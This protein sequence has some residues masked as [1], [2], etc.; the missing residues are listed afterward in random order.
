MNKRQSYAS[1]ANKTHPSLFD[2]AFDFKLNTVQSDQIDRDISEAILS[3]ITSESYSSIYD[4]TGEWHWLQN[5][6]QHEFLSVLQEGKLDPLASYMAN[7]FRNQATYGY[8]SPSF[9]DI[10]QHN[11]VTVASDILCN[12]DTCIEFTDIESL[13]TLATPSIIGNPFGLQLISTFLLP[14]TPRHYYAYNCR[15]LFKQ[16]S[17]NEP[18]VIEIGGGYGGFSYQLSRL[19]PSSTILI[20]DLAPSLV[21]TFY[22]LSKYGKQCKFITDFTD[23]SPGYINLIS[24]SLFARLSTRN[25]SS[26]DI[27]FNSR[28]FCEMSQQ[29]CDT[30]I[31][32]INASNARFCYHENSNYLLF[33]DSERHIELMADDFL[34]DTNIYHLLHKSI[35]PFT[36]G[37]GRYREYIYMNNSLSK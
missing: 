9:L 37:S 30:Y 10:S 33:P 1:I 26:P 8:I 31:K 25:L 20:V 14:D 27:I 3:F 22:F 36:G 4:G 5:N 34:I 7:M 18:F 13:D 2:Y 24:S 23:I 12:I 35:S 17:L 6:K 16:Y 15:Q 21:S 11:L 28:S 29:T 32:F 19:C